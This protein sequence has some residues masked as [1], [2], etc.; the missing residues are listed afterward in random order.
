MS[1]HDA[2][3]LVPERWKSEFQRFLSTG[4]ASPEFLDYLDKDPQGQS[5]VEIALKAESSAF[6][7]L[8]ETVRPVLLGTTAA[9]A[10]ELSAQ[11]S[12]AFESAMNLPPKERKHAFRGLRDTV[13]RLDEP[14][15]RQVKEVVRD[16][17]ES[18]IKI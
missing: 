4:N 15:R 1:D 18:L 7:K 8:A 11:I 16:L 14:A 13:N 3:A 10:T 2:V 12:S 9:H 5:A 17:G 6:E